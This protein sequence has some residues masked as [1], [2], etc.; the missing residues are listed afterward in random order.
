MTLS[1]VIPA[2]NE[3]ALLGRCLEAV[4]AEAR[5]AG[6]EVEIVVVDNAS[7]DSTRAVAERYPVRVVKR[8]QKEY[9][10]GSP[11]RTYRDHR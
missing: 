11:S 4:L 6:G 5:R 1:I 3:E 8:A 10:G 2:Y 9:R 7:T